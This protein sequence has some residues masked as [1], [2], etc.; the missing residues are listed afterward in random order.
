MTHDSLEKARLHMPP[1]HLLSLVLLGEKK[2]PKKLLFSC[3]YSEICTALTPVQG[4]VAVSFWW[5]G[6]WWIQGWLGLVVC[7]EFIGK[8]VC[9]RQ[10]AHPREWLCLFPSPEGSGCSAPLLQ[11]HCRQLTKEAGRD[12]SQETKRGQPLLQ[13]NGPTCHLTEVRHQPARVSAFQQLERSF[14]AIPTPQSGI[15]T[16]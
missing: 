4:G 6:I 13:P 2:I 8:G 15:G 12:T 7:A 11:F 3:S 1:S 16:R 5:L 9:R 14:A 10:A